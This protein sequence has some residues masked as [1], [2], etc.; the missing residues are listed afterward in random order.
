MDKLM[1]Y[2]RAHPDYGIDIFYSTPSIYVDYVHKY[3]SI[4]HIRQDG[5]NNSL[6]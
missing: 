1:A 4:K 6:Q 3:E 2:I 5:T